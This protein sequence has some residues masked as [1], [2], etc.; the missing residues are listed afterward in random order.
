M[1]CHFPQN[2]QCRAEAL[3]LMLTDHQYLS[4]KDGKPLSGLM[5]DHLIGG[6]RMVLR[7]Q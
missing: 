1:N 7:G 3:E 2:E 5:Q 4:A 6:V